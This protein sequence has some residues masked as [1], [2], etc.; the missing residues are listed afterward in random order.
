MDQTLDRTAGTG[1]KMTADELNAYL[2]EVFPQ[3]HEGGRTHVVEKAGGMFARIR[4]RYHDRHLRPGGTIS[5]PSMMALADFALYVAIL[6]EIGKVPLAVTT[7]LSINFLR[8]PAQSDLLGDCTLLKVGQRL[9]IGEVAIR[10]DGVDD[11]VAHVV[12]T[13]SI[14]AR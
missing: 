1:S 2:D 14:P 13:Y 8:K 5:G 4:M 3:M 6:A 11:L 12:G 9:A 10:S 7:N